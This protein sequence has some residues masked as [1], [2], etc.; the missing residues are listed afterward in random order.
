MTDNY[1][2]KSSREVFVVT[3][4]RNIYSIT[5]RTHYYPN[6]S[7]SG[8]NKMILDTK[9]IMG[10]TLFYTQFNATAHIIDELF[11]S[12]IESG[13]PR[14]VFCVATVASADGNPGAGLHIHLYVDSPSLSFNCTATNLHLVS[15][16]QETSNPSIE[17]ALMLSGNPNLIH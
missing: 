10:S 15:T 11:P 2:T 13:G 12:Q 17:S 8:D 7:T 14:S 3:T 6:S 5:H 4:A 1:S 9:Q 16:S